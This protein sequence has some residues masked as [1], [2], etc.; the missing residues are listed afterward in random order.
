MSRSTPSAGILG[1]PA[2]DMPMI[3]HGLGLSWQNRWNE[4][5]S[6]LGRITR[7]PWTK[8]LATPAVVSAMP[9]RQDRRARTRGGRKTAA[10][11]PPHG[12]TDAERPAIDGLCREADRAALGNAGGGRRPF[13]D[14][15]GA[16]ARRRRNHCAHLAVAA[17]QGRQSRLSQ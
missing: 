3:G 16:A 11:R 12:A 13:G 5:A 4:E 8:P 7:L 1:S 14:A 2:S 17:D 15:R 10:A 6:F 9:L